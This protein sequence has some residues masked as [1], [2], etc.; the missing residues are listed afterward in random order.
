MTG[1]IC[2]RTWSESFKEHKVLRRETPYVSRTSGREFHGVRTL[3]PVEP[4]LVL[5][6]MDD[7]TEL[8]QAEEALRQSEE[9]LKAL[10]QGRAH[11]HPALAGPRR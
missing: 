7:V 8:K 3:A 11:C 2:G 4:D 6:L 9:R 1:R 5:S 10:V